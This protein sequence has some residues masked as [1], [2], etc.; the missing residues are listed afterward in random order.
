MDSAGFRGTEDLELAVRPMLDLR[1]SH[2][3]KPSPDFGSL[4]SAEHAFGWVVFVD[5]NTEDV[6]CPEWLQPIL[7]YAVNTKCILIN[8]DR[9]AVRYPELFVE[10][11][12]PYWDMWTSAN[13]GSGAVECKVCGAAPGA[14]CSDRSGEERGIVV[15]TLRGK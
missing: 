6:M 3:P 12:W 5:P 11:T 8:F 9:D 1:T 13:E 2:M 14:Q 15:H 10:Y 4:R 7:G